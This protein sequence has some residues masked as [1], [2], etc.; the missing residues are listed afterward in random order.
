MISS[1]DISSGSSLQQCIRVEVGRAGLPSCSVSMLEL[2]T[3]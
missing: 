3:Q 2:I 1:S